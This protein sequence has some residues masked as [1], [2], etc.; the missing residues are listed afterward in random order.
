VAR[1]LALTRLGRQA[2]MDTLDVELRQLAGAGVAA[3]PD[4]AG[5]PLGQV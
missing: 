3:S 5:R 1:R 2:V 4:R